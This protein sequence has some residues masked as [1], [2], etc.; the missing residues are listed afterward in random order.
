MLRFAA[1]LLVSSLCLPSFTAFDAKADGLSISFRD[2]SWA[3]QTFP[4]K[5]ANDYAIEGQ[6]LTIDSERSVSMLYA[7][8]PNAVW[9]ARSASWDWKVLRSVPG[10]DLTKKGDDD[11]NIALYFIFLPAERAEATQDSSI[12]RLLREQSARVLVYVWG[13]D[14]Q[15][16][17]LLPSP[18]MDTRGVTIVQRPS[19]TGE[20]SEQIDLAADFTRAFGTAPTALAGL[21]VSADSDDTRAIIDARLS[22]LTLR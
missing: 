16:G 22:A 4:F 7:R 14:H 1:L 6:T 19:G 12:R 10:T 20:F 3:E 15:Q 5:R 21:A 9:N 2:G 13:G 11:R 18:Y 8:L 17:A